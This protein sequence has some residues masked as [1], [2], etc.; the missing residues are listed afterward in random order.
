MK[1][2]L[3]TDGSKYALAAAAKCCDLLTISK[4]SHLRIVSVADISQPVRAEYF[5]VS[6]DFY[7]TLSKQL[8]ET[9]GTYV[10]MTKQ[11]VEKKV[12]KEAQIETAVLVG[13]P[14]MS[15]VEDAEDWGADLIVVGSHGYGFFERMLIGSVSDAILHHSPC[16]VLVVKIDEEIQEE[17]SD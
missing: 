2:L 6:N 1:I 17:D 3:A 11:L 7:L 8:K 12:G 15:I 5:G 4:E 16:S 13:T 14:K 10:E 9:A